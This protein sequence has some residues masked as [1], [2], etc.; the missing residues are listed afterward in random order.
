MSKYNKVTIPNKRYIKLKVAT[1]I[2]FLIAVV[3]AVCI[4]VVALVRSN[5]LN[6]QVYSVTGVVKAVDTK[7]D[8][9]VV[10]LDDD[11]QFTAI[12]VQEYIPDL[13]S[14]VGK[15]VTL[16][17]PQKQLQS[18]LTWILGITAG[19]E[20]IVDHN[21]A[22]IDMRAEN[23][24][25]T[26]VLS[27][28]VGICVLASCA[29]YAWQKKTPRYIQEDIVKAYCEEFLLRQPSCPEYRRSWIIYIVYAVFATLW[30]LTLNLIGVVTD[31]KT[32]IIA[33]FITA[34]TLAVVAFVLFVW[35]I[36]VWL[37]RKERKYYAQNFP[38]DFSDISHTFLRKK[39]KTLLQE[40]LIS[41]RKEFP[42][43]YAE[44]GNDIVVDFT[45]KGVTL[46]QIDYDAEIV[47]SAQEVFDEGG[48]LPSANIYLCDLTYEQLDL[49][50]VAYFRKKDH[51]LFVV[52]KSRLAEDVVLPNG[53]LTNDIFILLDTNLWATLKRFDVNVENLDRIL[54]NKEQLIE[55]NCKF[56]KKTSK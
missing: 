20:V 33:V 48:N 37:P 31:D 23:T 1:A 26:I 2:L 5:N 32:T 45:E 27:V 4:I 17:V 55:E 53:T 43:R 3:F 41:E 10:I 14:L 22:L 12:P 51:S 34:N 50:A 9:A 16:I 15:N 42:D 7:G 28:I 8:N 49:E 11:T 6:G 46:S 21:T 40:E 38:F 30:I 35:L 24:T 52:V 29:T 36:C 39:Y 47:P 44:G 25:A 56:R 13:E 19:D 18:N 54:E